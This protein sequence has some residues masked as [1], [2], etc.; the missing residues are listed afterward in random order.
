M[1]GADIAGP[2]SRRGLRT[3]TLKRLQCFLP[4]HPHAN[5]TSCAGKRMGVPGHRATPGLNP[6]S[7]MLHNGGQQSPTALD[8][9]LPVTDLELVTH[10]LCET[11]PTSSPAV[12]EYGAA[13]SLSRPVS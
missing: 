9:A 11:R 3:Q 5:M 8:L 1:S 6:A 7:S 13:T 12:I 10:M 4:F 2:I